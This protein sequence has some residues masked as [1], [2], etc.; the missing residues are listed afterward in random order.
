MM[1]VSGGTTASRVESNRRMSIIRQ[2][3]KIRARFHCGFGQCFEALTCTAQMS[4][5]CGQVRQARTAGRAGKES[6]LIAGAGE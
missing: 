3:V 6:Q 2:S 5:L 1:V 4:R